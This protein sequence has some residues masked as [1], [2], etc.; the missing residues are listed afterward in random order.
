MAP[1]KLQAKIAQRQQLM[2]QQYAQL[3]E[4]EKEKDR[5][6]ARAMLQ[7]I[8]GQQGVSEDIK[9]KD[10]VSHP[11]FGAG[12]V[13]KSWPDGMISVDFAD[14]PD[15]ITKE[16]GVRVNMRPGSANY[17]KL[18][19]SVAE[20]GSPAQQA[21]IAIAMKK[22]DKKP[23]TESVNYW[24]KLQAERSKKLNTLV[25]ELKESIK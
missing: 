15:P 11:Q 16:P 14:Y 21:A 24:H 13:V 7:A 12:Y 5:V 20:A 17:K 10:T 23:K 4:E 25:N 3:P 22:A 19:K 18:T 1:E 2:T 9:Y 6:V 8:T